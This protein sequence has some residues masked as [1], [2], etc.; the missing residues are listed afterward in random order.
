[1]T[2]VLR[3]TRE[4]LEWAVSAAEYLEA[5][6]ALLE[7]ARAVSEAAGRLEPGNRQAAELVREAIE[8]LVHADRAVRA[9]RGHDRRELERL[10]AL[11]RYAVRGE[12]TEPAQS[13]E[14]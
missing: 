8:T 11:Q 1:M 2:E 14:A 3:K 4:R 12:R 5:Q 10:A 7:F 9:G 13:L 6:Q